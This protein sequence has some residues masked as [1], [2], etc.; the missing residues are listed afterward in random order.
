MFPA[1]G[2][3]YLVWDAIAYKNGK[4][5]I[6]SSVVLED[7]EFLRATVIPDDGKLEFLISLH[8]NS[9]KFTVF[10]SGYEVFTGKIFESTDLLV[11]QIQFDDTVALINQQD[12]IYKEFHLRG[13][14]FGLVQSFG[15]FISIKIDLI[16]SSIYKD[17][18]KSSVDF[19]QGFIKWHDWVAFIDSILQVCMLTI[20]TRK[21]L[22]LSKIRSVR[23]DPKLQSQKDS[24]L[25]YNFSRLTETMK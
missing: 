15:R 16:S 6:E 3:I 17:I 7:V 4:P 5:T 25:P 13:Y 2:L 14:N 18:E 20:P 24:V 1:A 22:I 11:P 12:D 10:E 23:I 9:G 19:V 21:L 8:C